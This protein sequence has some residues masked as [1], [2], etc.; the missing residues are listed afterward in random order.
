MIFTGRAGVDYVFPVNQADA[1]LEVDAEAVRST[2]SLTLYL[3]DLNALRILATS[4][5]QITLYFYEAN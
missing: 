2:N 5:F 1:N 4:T 3:T